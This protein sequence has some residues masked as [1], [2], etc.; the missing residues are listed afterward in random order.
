MIR[1]PPRSTLFPYTT[2]FRSL[3][4]LN[5]RPNAGQDRAEYQNCDG[6]GQPDF[7]AAGV[8]AGGAEIVLLLHHMWMPR[9]TY[10]R[11]HFYTQPGT[12]QPS[13]PGRAH[14]SG[15]CV[16]DEKREVRKEKRGRQA[17]NEGSRI[18]WQSRRKK[19]IGPIPSP[20]VRSVFGRSNR[21]KRKAPRFSAR[22]AARTSRPWSLCRRL[23]RSQCAESLRREQPT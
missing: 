12:H 13:R 8:V 10:L 19:F 18:K 5:A 23:K 16:R 4:R 22:A 11:W 1:R 14:T 7:D 20:A 17:R 9:W 6:R 21:R 2:L 15:Q 3:E